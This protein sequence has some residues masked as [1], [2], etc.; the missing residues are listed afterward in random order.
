MIQRFQSLYIL[1]YII[2]KCYLLY[3]YSIDK[4][5]FHF[6]IDKVDLYLILIILVII[7]STITVFSFKN[8]KIQIKLL[9]FLII[10]QVI[11]LT[12]ISILAYKVDNPI[13]FLHNY[14]TYHYLLGL[15]LLLLSLRGI[16]K[17]QKLIDSIDRIR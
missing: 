10:I 2:N 14:H 12:S 11:I 13:N 9:Y 6:F 1:F 8:R 7:F 4:N 5:P 16:K 15:L 3:K 17:D